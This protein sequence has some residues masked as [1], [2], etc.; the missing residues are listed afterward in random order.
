MKTLDLVLIIL[1]TVVIVCI[2]VIVYG[3][4]GKASVVTN[5]TETG[6]KIYPLDRDATVRAEGPLGSTV[7]KISGGV[8]RVESSPCRDK[9]CILK[10]E[11]EKNGD[12]TACMPNRVFIKIEGPGDAE[13]DDVSY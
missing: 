11:L 7:I 8:V 13:T 10:G 4:Q 5:R 12:W 6:V 9:L 2:S 1:I 3:G